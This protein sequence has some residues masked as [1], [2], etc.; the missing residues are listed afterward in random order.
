MT[1]TKEPQHHDNQTAA[2]TSYLVHPGQHEQMQIG[3]KE[4]KFYLIEDGLISP[5]KLCEHAK[6]RQGT[7]RVDSTNDYVAASD[8]EELA[9]Q[10]SISSAGIS[11]ALKENRHGILSAENKSPWYA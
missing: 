1:C 11:F 9:F 3:K 10:T 5:S 4:G 6:K 8:S 2:L 7:R